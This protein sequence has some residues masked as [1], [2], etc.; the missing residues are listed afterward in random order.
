MQAE[1]W[2]ADF[3]SKIETILSIKP[4]KLKNLSPAK[5]EEL[6]GIALFQKLGVDVDFLTYKALANE[7]MNQWWE[8]MKIHSGALN[9][10]LMYSIT[11]L[12]KASKQAI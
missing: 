5:V 2:A 8:K 7:Y 6:G 1:L 4:K 12:P 3:E 11:S 10:G 9:S